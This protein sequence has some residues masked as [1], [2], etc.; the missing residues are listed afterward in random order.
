MVREK[1]VEMG[2]KQSRNNHMYKWS[3]LKKNKTMGYS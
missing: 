3:P 2:D 1:M